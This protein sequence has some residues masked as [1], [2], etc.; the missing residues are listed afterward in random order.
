MM[1]VGLVVLLVLVVAFSASNLGTTGKATD[2]PCQNTEDGGYNIYVKGG[3][4]GSDYTGSYDKSEFC[5]A[6]GSKVIEYKCNFGQGAPGWVRDEVDCSA[7]NPDSKC[8][9]GACTQ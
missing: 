4:V 1:I 5:S 3:I 6:D 2:Y 8:V 7:F 9:D